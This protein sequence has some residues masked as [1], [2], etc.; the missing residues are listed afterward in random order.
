MLI[1]FADVGVMKSTSILLFADG[2]AKLPLCMALSRMG[3]GGV[4]VYFHSFLMSALDMG[5][6]THPDRFRHGVTPSAAH[7]TGGRVGTNVCLHTVEKKKP[8]CPC[9]S[10]KHYS[11]EV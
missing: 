3:G 8:S 1:K 9:E 7:C 11:S 4:K 6:V 10:S 2:K 5:S